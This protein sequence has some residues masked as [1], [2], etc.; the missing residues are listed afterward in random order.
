MGSVRIIAGSLRGRRIVVPDVVGLR[1]TPNAVRE[2]LFNW[3]API[4]V[5][6]VCLDLFVGSGA[7]S[8]EALSRGAKRVVAFDCSKKSIKQLKE[9]ARLLAM[10]KDLTIFQAKIP[11]QLDLAI[12]TT[13]YQP[14]FDVVF[15]DPPFHQNLVPSTCQ[16]LV[17]LSSNF[18]APRALIYIETEKNLDVVTLTSFLPSTWKVLRHKTLGQVNYYLLTLE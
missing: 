11:Q 3:L 8:F 15:L 13:S 2:T 10:E 9:N 17:Q 5:D 7:L 4:I 6:A 16:R 14:K 1:P 18:L 12:A